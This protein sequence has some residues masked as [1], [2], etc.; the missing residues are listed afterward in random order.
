MPP[1]TRNAVAVMNDASSLA[2]EGHRGGDVLG[3]REAAHR[4]VNESAFGGDRIVGEQLL[5]QRSANRARA[6]GDHS[7]AFAGELHAESRLSASTP[8]FEA[9]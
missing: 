9:V 5:Q 4:D 8:P 6:Q 2:E 3:A 7:D 1:S